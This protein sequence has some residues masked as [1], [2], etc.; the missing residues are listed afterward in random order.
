MET[1]IEFFNYLIEQMRS[2][3]DASD[4]FWERIVM[5]LI[6]TYFE[7]KIMVIEFSYGI[8]K[9][10]IEGVGL[11]DAITSAWSGIDSQMLAVFTYLRIPE[12]INMLLSA[13]VTRFVMGILPL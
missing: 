7:L 3:P 2:I 11:S 10:F 5:W 8:A 12:G 4:T 1:M 6:I 13:F 9:T